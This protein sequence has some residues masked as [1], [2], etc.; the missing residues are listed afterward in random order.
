MQCA[1]V[2]N[3]TVFKIVMIIILD[4]IYKVNSSSHQN[5]PAQAQRCTAQVHYPTLFVFAL[6]FF[7]LLDVPPK[8][9][10]LQILSNFKFLIF[11][12]DAFGLTFKLPP[13]HTS[14]WIDK[15]HK[16]SEQLIIQILFENIA[17]SRNLF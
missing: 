10:V 5:D 17:N 2:L 9:S 7:F 14:L 12:K 4:D 13:T 16:G 3:K 1:L 11:L 6:S 15:Q 8:L